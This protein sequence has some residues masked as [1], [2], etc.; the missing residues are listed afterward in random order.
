MYGI[1]LARPVCLF[2][3]VSSINPAS[4]VYPSFDGVFVDLSEQSVVSPIATITT[5]FVRY[6]TQEM[7]EAH[8]RKDAGR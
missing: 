8:L 1:R 6:P 2:T 3:L 4:S 5:A 7:G